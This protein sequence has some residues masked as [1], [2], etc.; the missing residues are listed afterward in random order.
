LY[1]GLVEDR[2]EALLKSVLEKIVYF[3][4]RSEQLQNDL[5]AARAESERLRA[6]LAAAA[7]REID[8]RRVVA[9]LEVR[10]SRSHAL[11]DEAARAAEALRRERA[12]LIGKMLEA[13][14]IH[15]AGKEL[16]ADPYDLASFISELRGEVISGRAAHQTQA[17]TALPLA[18]RAAAPRDVPPPPPSPVTQLASQLKAEGRFV[19]P[20]LA[21]Q[22]G[23]HTEE[24]L[25]GFSVRELSAP[26]AAARTRAA[27]RLKALGQSAAAPA[28]AAALHAETD[29]QVLAAL[30]QAFACFAKSEGVPVV[31]PLLT[32][33]SPDVRI[34]ALKALL[35]LDPAQG[36]PHLAAAVKDP[37]R[38]VRRRASLLALSLTGSAALKL[39]EEA[40]A[41]AA[42]EVRALAALVLGASAAESARPLLLS[43]MRDRDVKVRRAAAQSLS[44]LLGRDVVPMVELDEANRRRE[45][46]KLQHVPSKPVLYT[47]PAPLTAAAHAPGQVEKQKV[48][49]VTVEALGEQLCGPLLTE[50]RS[51]I[52]GRTPAELCANLGQPAQ[53][54]SVACA[55]LVARGQAVQ[56]GQKFFVA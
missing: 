47:R 26:D 5:D 17:A 38:A 1:E 10:S 56:R 21:L 20:A 53:V 30:L 55:Q 54:V 37:D 24:T 49:V 40:I 19:V 52:R 35:Q 14:R 2:P 29:P 15:G 13:S 41:D 31:A 51:A 25:F 28:L 27:E 50:L 16:D 18:S 12:E 6:D 8:L 36:G 44:R 39:G 11:A 22:G 3:E 42:P 43:A 9:E 23:G 4:A 32:A 46:R 7:Q 33:P 45:V 48:A 34:A